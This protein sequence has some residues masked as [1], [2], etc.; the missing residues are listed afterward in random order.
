MKI[1]IVLNLQFTVEMVSNEIAQ[2]L[3]RIRLEVGLS[4]RELV[5]LVAEFKC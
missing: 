4:N 5:L 3:R 2:Y 1:V